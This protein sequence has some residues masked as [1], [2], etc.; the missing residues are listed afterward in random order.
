M[1]KV[2]KDASSK[3]YENTFFREF[4]QS[5][6]AV[7]Q[8]RNWNGILL[9]MPT[10]RTRE[11]LQIDCLLITP[12]QIIIIDFKNYSGTL[13]LPSDSDFYKKP[14]P[15]N[16]HL[17]VRAGSSINPF[18][19]LERQREKLIDELET[20]K[21]P[22]SRDAISTM[23][24][25]HDTIHLVGSIPRKLQ[26]RFFIADVTDYL[27][28]ITDIIDVKRA[29][30]NKTSLLNYQNE[31]TEQLFYL[32]PYIFDHH[33]TSVHDIATEQKPVTIDDD[34][35]TSI[36]KFLSSDHKIMTIDGGIGSHKESMIPYIR[37]A[38]FLHQF[39]SAFVL[40]YSNRFRKKLLK[41]QPDLD[42][43][44]S[45]FKTIYSFKNRKYD[46]IKKLIPLRT[47]PAF[48][49]EQRTLYIVY[50]SQLI[51]NSKQN[52][53]F[54]QFGSG[55]LLDDFLEYVDLE[56]YPERK[57]IFIGD[58]HQLSY[59][60]A[61]KGALNSHYL[62]GLLKEKK[63]NDT[64]LTLRIPSKKTTY[65][66]T[67]SCQNISQSIMNNQYNYLSMESSKKLKVNPPKEQ[68][69]LLKEVFENP[70]T[71]KIITYQNKHVDDINKKIK[72]QFLKNEQPLEIGDF[73]FFDATIQACLHKTEEQKNLELQETVRID[74]GD[75]GTIVN[76]DQDKRY[77]YSLLFD[78]ELIE[79]TFIW[80]YVKLE[81]GE[82]V[83]LYILENYITSPDKRL[84]DKE[85][86]TLHILLKELKQQALQQQPFTQSREFQEMLQNP[87]QYC[88]T[89]VN[90]QTVY[91]DPKDLRKLTT[92]EKRYREKITQQLYQPDQLYFKIFNV[93]KV[94]HA[95][96]MTVHKA[97]AYHFD[98]VIF[99]TARENNEGRMNKEYFKF[100][101]TG[102]G[103]ASNELTLISWTP[104]TPF[105]K[106]IFTEPKQ[107]SSKIK[108]NTFDPQSQID[109]ATQLRHFLESH[110]KGIA[111][112][113]RITSRPYLEIVTLEWENKSFDLFFHY[114]KKYEINIPQ[115]KDNKT[116]DIMPI[117]QA[118]LPKEEIDTPIT[119]FLQDMRQELLN[120]TITMNWYAPYEWQLIVYFTH[121]NKLTFVQLYY[122]SEGVISYF[123][124]LGGDKELYQQLIQWIQQ[125]YMGKEENM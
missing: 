81:S 90:H 97:L 84:N 49:E 83:Q 64:V 67:E 7:F 41:I 15:M 12:H 107:A 118:L 121:Q 104:I 94:K 117:I 74:N 28:Q 82:T 40:S 13:Q 108:I 111:T 109:M 55:Q 76:I 39:T 35:Q 92:F 70:N 53:P 87:D 125:K 96:A 91:R 115:G 119:H 95:W 120:E 116:S 75:F 66:F 69:Q 68:V 57:I 2:Y 51:T 93:A 9:G 44:E 61:N 3:S 106:T 100:L 73:I 122:K 23:V 30:T 112:I 63:L 56:N 99:D 46:G 52:S 123:N 59:G 124:Y 54:V 86:T 11:D 102:I 101:Y 5:L 33:T 48:N 19:Q 58:A 88:E 27:N 21:L 78:Q 42:D 114:N 79:L 29:R 65:P 72:R 38:A 4:S 89:T 43:V 60:A 6:A 77:Q 105:F 36:Q 10:C 50:D 80:C 8:Q 71:K 32:K 25:F 24:L 16:E 22:I 20:Q 31:I 26:L 18:L 47:Q 110:L 98:T 17:I 1:L 85:L 34:L 113:V 45:L 103:I 14:W 62:K 37:Q